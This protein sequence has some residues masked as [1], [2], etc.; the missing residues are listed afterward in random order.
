MDQ[1]IEKIKKFMK[2]HLIG[3]GMSA[4][5]IKKAEERQKL[6]EQMSLTD[7]EAILA[8]RKKNEE[9]NKGYGGSK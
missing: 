4:D 2:D 9:Q 7:Q 6:L 1:Q 5:A 8:E 3:T